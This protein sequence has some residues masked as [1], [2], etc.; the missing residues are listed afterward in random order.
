MQKYCERNLI[1]KHDY[2]KMSDIKVFTIINTVTQ[3]LRV[4]EFL[5]VAVVVKLQDSGRTS[6]IVTDFEQRL[7]N[8]VIILSSRL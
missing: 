1:L 4:T 5:T 7:S 3:A 6:I 2:F 8:S